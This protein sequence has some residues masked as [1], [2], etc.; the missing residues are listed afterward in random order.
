MPGTFIDK[1]SEIGG[2]TYVGR[3]CN[4][5]RTPIGRY[6]SIANNVSIGQGEH[7]VDRISTSSLFY[8]NAYDELTRK[9]CEIGNDVWIGVDAIIL[10]G[11]TVGDGA[12]I[13]A[14]SVVT[15]DVPPFAIVVGSPARLVRYRFDENLRQVIQQS[16]WWRFDFAKASEMIRQIA[17]SSACRPL[18]ERRSD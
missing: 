14:N 17:E 6:C 1:K 4:I 12:V 13:G 11:V 9:T 5:T 15:K 18:N 2:Y 10:R 3:N 8:V 7:Y 16:C